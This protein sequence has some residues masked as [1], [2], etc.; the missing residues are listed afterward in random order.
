LPHSSSHCCISLIISKFNP[1][2]AMVAIWN[3]IIVS[4]QVLT[5]K[6]S[7][8][9]WYFGWNASVRGF[10]VGKS[11]FWL[12]DVGWTGCKGHIFS[13]IFTFSIL[14]SANLHQSLHHKS[15]WH[16]GG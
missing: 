6:G 5:Q 16:S 15:S 11:V 8:E 7:L 10:T 13:L 14:H 12:V 9:L 3:H 4:F 2:S 1:L